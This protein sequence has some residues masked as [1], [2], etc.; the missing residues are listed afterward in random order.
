MATAVGT[1][2]RWNGESRNDAKALPATA[3]V[4]P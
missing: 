1:R 2:T 4:A 3:T